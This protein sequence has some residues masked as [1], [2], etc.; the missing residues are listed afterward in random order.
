MEFLETSVVVRYL[1]KDPPDMAARAARLITG[2]T[3]LYITGTALAET[4]HV[5]RDVYAVDRATVVDLLR[6]LIRDDG[7]QPYPAD[8]RRAVEGLELCRPSGKVS[9]PDA[10]IWAE[11]LSAG[12]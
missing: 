12:G 7:V 11:A 9:I 3:P 5:L 2:R 1:T 8:A 10:L 4:A 6:A